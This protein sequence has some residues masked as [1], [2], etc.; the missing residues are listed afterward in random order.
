[1]TSKRFEQFIKL[2][3][4][5][6]TTPITDHYST[7][8]KIALRGIQGSRILNPV[9]YILNYELFGDPLGSAVERAE[10]SSPHEVELKDLIGSVSVA[11]SI[12]GTLRDLYDNFVKKNVFLEAIMKGEE[13]PKGYEGTDCD[14]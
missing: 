7:L 11:V 2:V 4:I 14:D 10:C 12:H 6:D 8:S 5:L 13:I 3:H 1:M 9:A